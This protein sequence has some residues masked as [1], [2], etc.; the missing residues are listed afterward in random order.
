MPALLAPSDFYKTFGQR[1]SHLPADTDYY[2]RVYQST[3]VFKQDLPSYLD[4]Y[5]FRLKTHDARLTTWLQQRARQKHTAS[6]FAA[7]LNAALR[8]NKLI[9]ILDS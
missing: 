7:E 2:L 5:G 1:T 8:W 9:A 6:T 3:A 4:P